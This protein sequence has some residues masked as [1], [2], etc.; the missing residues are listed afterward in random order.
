MLKY[1]MVGAACPVDTPDSNK[2]NT[3]IKKMPF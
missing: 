2:A 3:G 1:V